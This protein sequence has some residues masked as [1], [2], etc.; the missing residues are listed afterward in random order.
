MKVAVAYVKLHIGVNFFLSLVSQMLHNNIWSPNVLVPKRKNI[1][2]KQIM[3][4]IYTNILKKHAL[5]F[6]YASKASSYFLLT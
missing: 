6:S 2:I 5:T 3:S 1:I 4:Y